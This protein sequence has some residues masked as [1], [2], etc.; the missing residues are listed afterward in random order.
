MN[1]LLQPSLSWTLEACFRVIFAALLGA[2]VGI[3]REHHG[4]SA[5]FRTQ[6]LVAMGSSLAM[7][8]SLNFGHV[9]GSIPREFALQV[10]PGR[11]AYSVMGGIGF[12][13]AGVIMKHGLDVRGITTAASLWCNAA[14]GLAS[15]FGMYAIAMVAT[16]MTLLA[17][18]LL[19]RVDRMIPVSW[20][21]VV[22]FK[23]KVGQRDNLVFLRQ[24][25]ESRNI[26]ITAEEHTRDCVNNVETIRL[27][28]RIVSRGRPPRID[29]IPADPDLLE[30]N[31]R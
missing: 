9:Y 4:R 19:N 13:G 27:E 20:F 8:V 26:S 24:L 15:G 17:L 2:L 23:M 11:V 29:W 1:W 14:I 3:E 16:G 7:V 12:L 6:L 18:V 25:I 21:R 10:D 5:G 30:F 28:L 22:T 31:I